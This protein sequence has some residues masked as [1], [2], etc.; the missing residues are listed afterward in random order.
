MLYIQILQHLRALHF[1][2]KN[3]LSAFD[4]R[5]QS[6]SIERQYGLRAFVGAGRLESQKTSLRPGKIIS[7][8]VQVTP[9]IAASG[10]QQD[11]ERIVER[12][13]R[14]D[15]KLTVIYG[16]S[17]VGKS[18]MIQAGLIPSIN[19][20][21]IDARRI[22]VVLQQVYTDWVTS[23]RQAFQSALKTVDPDQNLDNLETISDIV[24]ALHQNSQ[25]DLLT[26]LIFD[27]FEDFFFVCKDSSQRRLF[28]D[29]FQECLN[30]PFIK[31]ILSL[32][33]GY[34]HHLLELNRLV[35][36]EVINNNILDKEILYYIGSLSKEEAKQVIELV[37]NQTSFHL[38]PDLIEVLVDDLAGSLGEI[39]PIELQLVGSQLQTDNIT[40]LGQYQN[41]AQY[42][43][44]TLVGR[45]LGIRIL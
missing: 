28:Y 41:L 6:R 13:G 33:E 43:K 15:S 40:T 4:M 37:T 38:H 39:R 36:L 2:Q 21:V 29:F 11:V 10:R 42:K 22:F 14:V 45:F 5:Q 27:Q 31:I 16:Q 44:E 8:K 12:I 20:Q 26:V 23:F 17:G 34:L 35:N 32:Q 19:S 7:Q 24:T 1:K 18:S 25:R 9:E 3:Y 30:T